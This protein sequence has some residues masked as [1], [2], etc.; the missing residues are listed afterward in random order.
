MLIKQ[1]FWGI[2]IIFCNTTTYNKNTDHNDT[3][4]VWALWSITMI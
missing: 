3:D 1:Y 4:T 2:S